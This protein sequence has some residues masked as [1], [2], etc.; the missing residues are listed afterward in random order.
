MSVD[1]A[2]FLSRGRTKRFLRDEQTETTAATLGVI[3]SPAH[4]FP[5][6]AKEHGIVCPVVE[7]FVRAVFNIRHKLAFGRTIRTQL[8][9]D[10]AFWLDTLFLEEPDE[11]T[12]CCL[13]IAPGL[14]GFIKTI[15]ILLHGAPKPVLLSS[16]GSD[17]LIQMPGIVV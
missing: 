17:N 10:H 15:F 1:I 4:R 14:N 9:G 6:F 3:E 8:V 13:C 11:Q 2:D 7:A 12:L 5:A 16:D